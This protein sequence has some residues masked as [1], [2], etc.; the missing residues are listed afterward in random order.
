M[1]RFRATTPGFSTFA[2]A[3]VAPANATVTPEATTTPGG[4]ANTTINATAEPMATA[5]T[6]PVTTAPAAPLVYAPFLAPLAFLLW[7]R[8][9]H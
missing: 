6:V 1:C 7:R 3:A 2:I 4:E 8:R 9:N 5:T